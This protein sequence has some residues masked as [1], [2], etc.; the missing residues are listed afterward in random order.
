MRVLCL[1]A[2]LMLAGC[3]QKGPLYMAPR[4]PAQAAPPAQATPLPAASEQTDEDD[5]DNQDESQ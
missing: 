5:N 2:M 3:G 4:E 1:L